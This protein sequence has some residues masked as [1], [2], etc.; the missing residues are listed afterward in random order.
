MSIDRRSFLK[1]LGIVP[2]AIVAARFLHAEPSQTLPAVGVI[3][4][5]RLPQEPPTDQSD[6]R[7]CIDGQWYSILS[8]AVQ[9]H[10]NDI[11]VG[12]Y[13]D[14]YEYVAIG[15]RS[16]VTVSIVGFHEALALDRPKAN[17]RLDFTEGALEFEAAFNSIVRRK[18][19]RAGGEVVRPD[20]T[21]IELQILGEHKWNLAIA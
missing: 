6:F 8:I 7:F 12:T 9:S 15:K 21:D 11:W 17:C 14:P 20:L 13:D 1:A 3:P 2:P 5:S 16:T 19:V 10:A 18:A 4:G